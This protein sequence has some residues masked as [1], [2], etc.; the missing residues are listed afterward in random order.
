MPL[1]DAEQVADLK[2][3]WLQLPM[4]L[5]EVAAIAASD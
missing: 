2:Q 4:L 1:C 3:R 5:S